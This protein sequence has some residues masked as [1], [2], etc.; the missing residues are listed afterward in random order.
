MGDSKIGWTQSTW[1]P[2][3]WNCTPISPGCAHCYAHTLARKWPANAN[4]GDFL[5]APAIRETAWKEV[6]RLKPGPCF[7]CSMTDLFHDAIPQAWIHRVYNTFTQRPDITWLVLTKRIERAAAL[8]PH[9]AY[10][11]NVWIG[12]TVEG[13]DYLPRLDYLREITQ[14]AGRFVSFE[15]LLGSVADADLTG[16]NW[17]ICGGE[18]G[19]K[20][21]SFDHRWAFELAV[22]ARAENIPFYFKQG[23]DRLPGRDRELL[24]RTFDEVPTGF[25]WQAHQERM[26]I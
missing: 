10:A 24:G 8:A 6:K 23:S 15:P 21:R 26:A 25:H 19:P 16:L 17:I 2:V 1:N 18:S 12:T 11:P 9:L 3:T 7:V 4:G 14:A 22:L 5:H 20:R 13:P